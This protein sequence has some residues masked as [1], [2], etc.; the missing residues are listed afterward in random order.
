MSQ[1]GEK[2]ISAACFAAWNHRIAKAALNLG[3]DG[4][5]D[6]L[7]EAIRTVSPFRFALMMVYRPVAR[8][9]CVH[10]T[11]DNEAAKSAVSRYTEATYVLNPV[12]NAFLAGLKP[13]IYRIT[14]LAPDAYFS[15][16]VFDSLEIGLHSDEE[17]GYRT[18]G[19]PAGLAELIVAVGLPNGEMLEISLSRPA[20]EGYDDGSISRICLIEP[21]ISALFNVF[22]AQARARLSQAANSLSLDD[23]LRDFGRDTLT[24]RER[25]VAQLI[26]RGH[27]GESISLH[28]DIS[29]ATVKSHRQNIYGKLNVATQQEL[30]SHFL[31]SLPLAAARAHKGDDSHPLGG[32]PAGNR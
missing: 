26:L 19:W 23:L 14:E 24:Q 6:L 2:S 13:G 17:L 18:P 8:P 1:T 30:F 12:Y 5:P 31:K 11:F 7:L 9:Y 10:H 15:S 4:F 20:S 22:W 29:R 27:S 3:G 28:L 16:E 25:E 21:V 32:W